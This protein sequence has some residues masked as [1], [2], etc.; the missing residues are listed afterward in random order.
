MRL[1]MHIAGFGN[2][3]HRD[4]ICVQSMD[5]RVQVFE[6]DVHA[7]TRRLNNT[8]VPGPLCYVAKLD[9]FVTAN[10]LLEIECY[11]VSASESRS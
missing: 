10:S 9:A 6:Q 3:P 2:D 4:L 5:G 1:G 8:L 7:F 11:K